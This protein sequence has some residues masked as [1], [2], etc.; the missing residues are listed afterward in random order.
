MLTAALLAQVVVA[1]TLIFAG[2]LSD[3]Y[4]RRRIFMI[5]VVLTGIW[6][7][8]LFPM[9]ETRSLL[10]ITMAIATGSCTMLLSYGPLAAMFSELFITHVRYS[11][12]SLA[13]QTSAIV[14]GGVG[15]IIATA[16]YA[17]YHTNVWLSVFISA[18]CVMSLVCVS[19]LKETRGT[20]PVERPEPTV[21]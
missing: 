6:A 14:G 21:A 12:V 8:F 1:P 3:R 16:L 18:T 7:F 2:T 20:D 5:G 13:Y 4:G 19:V 9:I 15:P 17:R 10:W 11:A